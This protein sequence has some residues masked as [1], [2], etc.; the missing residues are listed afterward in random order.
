MDQALLIQ[1]AEQQTL[2]DDINQVKFGISCLMRCLMQAEDETRIHI[3]NKLEIAYLKLKQPSMLD[4]FY[5]SN[6]ALYEDLVKKQP[7]HLDYL[8]QSMRLKI[9]QMRHAFKGMIPFES[10][11]QIK[12]TCLAIFNTY[13]QQKDIAKFL[14]IGIEVM[15][16]LGDLGASTEKIKQP[17]HWH[18]LA[19]LRANRNR[20]LL[21]LLLFVWNSTVQTMDALILNMFK[22]LYS[23]SRALRKNV[24]IQIKLLLAMGHNRILSDYPKYTECFGLALEKAISKDNLVHQI[25]AHIGLGNL[26]IHH[27]PQMSQTHLLQ[28]YRDA[29]CLFDKSLLVEAL[30]G[31]AQQQSVIDPLVYLEEVCLHTEHVLNHQT[32]LNLDQCTRLYHDEESKHEPTVSPSLLGPISLVIQYRMEKQT[33]DTQKLLGYYHQA[34]ALKHIHFMFELALELGQRRIPYSNKKRHTFWGKLS[35]RDIKHLPKQSLFKQKFSEILNTE[36]DLSSISS[37]SNPWDHDDETIKEPESRG[38]LS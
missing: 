31:L 37:S 7:K 32:Q 9:H 14:K 33:M 21:D 3:T 10:K 19:L 8:Y 27:D 18:R 29:S 28:A 11:D 15:L 35:Y 24:D 34:K 26:L 2:T 30:L 13:E 5:Q 1:Y 23:D 22:G 20:H 38:C 4:A 6:I 16:M 12:A 17:H 25:V 36:D